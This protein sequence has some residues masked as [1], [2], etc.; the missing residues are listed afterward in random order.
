VPREL[1]TPRY[2]WTKGSLSGEWDGRFILPEMDTYRRIMAGANALNTLE[3]THIWQDPESWIIQEHYHVPHVYNSYTATTR[4]NGAPIQAGLP[5]RAFIS[6]NARIEVARANHGS[7]L[8]V[9]DARVRPTYSNTSFY[10]TWSNGHR[11]TD[12]DAPPTPLELSED[13]EG[14]GL[15]HL[16]ITGRQVPRP[17]YIPDHMRSMWTGEATLLGT[18]RTW[19]G[20]ITLRAT[21]TFETWM[22]TGYIVGDGNFVGRWRD[23]SMDVR[24]NAYEGPF[25]MRRRVPEV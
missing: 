20:L 1:G 13:E 11:G 19:D 2:R 17:D 9:S 25:V 8:D 10:Q 14:D 4:V 5:E 23:A 18:V 16:I 24:R 22:W 21:D 7:G 12:V 6:P 15:L 3:D